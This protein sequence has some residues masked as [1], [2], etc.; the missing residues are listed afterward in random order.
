MFVKDFADEYA[1]YR[2]AA[3]KAMAQVSDEGL[4]HIAA[5]DGNSIAMLARHLSGNLQSRFT[6]FLTSDGEKPWRD[7]DSEFADGTLARAEVDAAWKAAW[8]T[9]ESQLAQLSDDDLTRTVTIRGVSLTVHEALVRSVTHVATHVGQIVLLARI[10]A[11]GD[12]KWITIPKGQSPEYNQN[13]TFE[14]ARAHATA[15]GQDRAR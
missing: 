9:L 3:E 8:E 11:T 14:K 10:V 1:R 5:R 6:D 7:R 12:W 13:P 4:N 15:L 2:A